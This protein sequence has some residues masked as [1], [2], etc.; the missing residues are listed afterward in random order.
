[1][2]GDTGLDGM[3]LG[4]AL[5]LVCLPSVRRELAIAVR[6]TIRWLSR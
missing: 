3:F 6:Q 4:F 1:M 2:T 5:G